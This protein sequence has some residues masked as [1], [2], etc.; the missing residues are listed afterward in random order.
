MEGDRQGLRVFRKGDYVVIDEADLR[1]AAPESTETVEIEA[2]VEPRGDRPDALREAVLPGA[3]RR[4]RRRAT[5]CCARCWRRP[6]RSAIARVVIR[7]RQ[8]HRRA[9]RRAGDALM[10]WT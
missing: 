5:C 4:R 1:K 2:F 3:R 6:A 9:D 10:I 7:T 8:Y